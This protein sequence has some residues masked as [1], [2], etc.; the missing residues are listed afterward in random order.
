VALDYML[1]GY[2]NAPA[3]IIP[4]GSLIAVSQ[5]SLCSNPFTIY[6]KRKRA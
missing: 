1:G 5:S 4:R 2:S 6:S 3:G